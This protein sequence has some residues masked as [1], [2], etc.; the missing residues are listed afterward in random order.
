MSTK[1]K[2]GNEPTGLKQG[3]FYLL[4]QLMKNQ[5]KR[6]HTIHLELICQ[7]YDHTVLSVSVNPK[8]CTR[9][10]VSTPIWAQ[11]YLNM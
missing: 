7:I 11:S 9:F 4:R 3:L 5:D 8:T 2:N 6:T 10:F 1:K